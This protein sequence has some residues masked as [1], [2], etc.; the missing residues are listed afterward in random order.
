MAGPAVEMAVGLVVGRSVGLAAVV[1]AAVTDVVHVTVIA[2]AAVVVV[3]VVVEDG[4]FACAEGPSGAAG[5][6][7]GK[8]VLAP[9][10]SSVSYLAGEGTTAGEST[11][12]RASLWRTSAS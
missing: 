1:L 7:G 11:G 3:T 12:V 2:L 8:A 6:R 9:A 10:P 4:G 5:G